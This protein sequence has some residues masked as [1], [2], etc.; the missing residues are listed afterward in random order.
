MITIK[1]IFEDDFC[2]TRFNGSYQ[3]AF[4]YYHNKAF[5]YWNALLEREEKRTCIDLKLI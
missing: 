1:V 5:V 4:E 2:I 3:D